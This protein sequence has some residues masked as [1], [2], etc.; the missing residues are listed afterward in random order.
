MKIGAGVQGADLFE[1]ANAQNAIVLGG[2][3]PS[4]GLAGGYTQGGGH[5]ILSSL[6]GLGADQVL[7]WEVV[8]AQGQHLTATPKQNQDLYWALSGG[9]GGTYGVVISLI[10]RTH[11]PSIVGGAVLGF[12]SAGISNDTYWDAIAYWQSLQEQLVDAGTTTLALAFPGGF[13]ITPF[14]A[15]D[16]SVDQTTELLAP[17]TNY[18]TAHKIT[19]SLNVTSL[20]FI[21]HYQKYFG[22]SYPVAQFTGGRLIPRSVVKDNNAGL[23]STFRRIVEDSPYALAI[24]PLNV[25]HPTQKKPVAPNAV[26]PAWRDALFEVVI[27][28]A[29]NYTASLSAGFEQQSVLTNVV[30]PALKAVTP[31]SGTYLNE[32]DFQDPDWKEDFYGRNYGPLRAIKA[33]YDHDDLFYATTAVGS[34][35]WS[36]AL[37]GRLCRTK[38]AAE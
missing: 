8:T 6:Y 25:G 14:N 37:D 24:I 31:G 9:G 1:A 17:F 5:S 33:K 12:A 23:T 29:W 22:V 21:E 38:S 4:I 19:F 20:P 26:L 16:A 35:A 3:C 32:G 30:E 36:V 7:E 11:P 18:L 10:I 13:Q 15:P 28:A 34:D 27:L 2:N